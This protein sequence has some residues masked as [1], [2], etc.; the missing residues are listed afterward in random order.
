MSDLKKFQERLKFILKEFHELCDK[1]DIKYSVSSGTML[2]AIRHKGFIP[3]DDDIDVLMV[4][5]EYEKLL[6]VRGGKFRIE[7]LLWVPR[8]YLVN[9]DYRELYLDIFIFENAPNS[10]LNHN[11]KVFVIRFLQGS[12]KKN[13]KWSQYS[14]KE[15]IL[16]FIPFIF[17]KILPYQWKISIYDF[18]A[19]F[20]NE[21]STECLCAYKNEYRGVSIRYKKRVFNDY[22]LIPFEDIM[23]SCIQGYDEYL[24]NNYGDYMIPP[25]VSNRIPEHKFKKDS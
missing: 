7:N 18:I 5:S 9:D 6:K 1:H 20:D 11:L 10:I 21:S 24:T 4:R 22:I 16:L 3:W 25:P 12:L 19:E 23:L 2:G 14:F 8:F 15:K 13:I 17:G